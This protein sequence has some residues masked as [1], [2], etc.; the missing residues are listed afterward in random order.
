MYKTYSNCVFNVCKGLQVAKIGILYIATGRYISF[1]K[2]F[3]KRCEE[4]FCP[5]HQKQYFLF[6]DAKNVAVKS[7][8]KIIPHKLISPLAR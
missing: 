6:T 2:E 3:Y 4:Y 5:E 8:V 1:W 7:N